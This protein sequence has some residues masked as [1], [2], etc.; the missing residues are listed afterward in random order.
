MVR[1]I[2]IL[3]CLAFVQQLPAQETNFARY[4]K[5]SA[6][7]SQLRIKET[8][9]SQLLKEIAAK[10]KQTAAGRLR[11]VLSG[12]NESNTISS[13]WLAARQSKDLYVINLSAVVSKYIGETEKNLALL[14][15]KA[16]S[17]NCILLVDEADALFG[18]RTESK[19]D[20]ERQA[21]LTYLLERIQSYKGTVLISC[22]GT[23][24]LAT[25]G[26]HKFTAIKP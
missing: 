13:R 5:V 26:K 7:D 18:Q 10:K 19:E 1:I 11:L 6:A 12:D 22:S 21:A 3:L 24:C 9:K 23:D 14:F 4:I 20:K 8:V 16:E 15:D 2:T 25:L 17:M